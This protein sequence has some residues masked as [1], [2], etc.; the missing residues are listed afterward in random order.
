MC[1]VISIK[2]AT[3][4]AH[5]HT[6][7]RSSRFL[8][9]S[10]KDCAKGRSKKGA[11]RKITKDQ[12]TLTRLPGVR[13]CVYVTLKI[14]RRACDAVVLAVEAGRQQVEQEEEGPAAAS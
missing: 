7:K 13:V 8:W 4:K 9:G 12:D 2:E 3:Q 6:Q 14:S 5:T 10:V 11:K 1:D